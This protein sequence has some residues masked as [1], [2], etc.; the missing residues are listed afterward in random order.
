[1]KRK[2]FEFIRRILFLAFIQ[3]AVSISGQ[4][5]YYVSN[6]GN[7][8]ANGT[9]LGTAWATISKV[10]SATIVPGD[11]VLFQAG[12]VWREE[13]QLTQGASGAGNRVYYGRYGIGNNPKIIGSNKAI[14]WTN[15]A[16]TNVWQSAT[17]VSNP[18][19]GGWGYPGNV[20]FVT[21]DSTSWGVFQD[22][23]ANFSNLS[24][25]LDWTW[26]SNT[27]YVYSPTDP[28]TR[29]DDVE[30]AERDLC[31]GFQNEQ[32]SYIEFNGID[33][34]YSKRA[35]YG[36]MSYPQADNQTDVTIR[37]CNI[38]YIGI[39][40]GAC[41]YGIEAFHSNF[42]VENCTITDC[43][44]RG[45]SFN[46]YEATVDPPLTL[47][48][49]IIRNNVFKRGYHTTSLDIATD[50][51]EPGHSMENIY[52]YNNLVDDHEIQMTGD[53]AGSNQ[54]YFQPY[55]SYFNNI[56]VVNN[57]FI[58]A[59]TRNILVTGGDN[60]YIY[61]NTVFSHN[62][63]ITAPPYSNIN[64][65]RDATANVSNNIIYD[66]LSANT[67]IDNWCIMSDTPDGN[68]VTFQNLDYNLYYHLVQNDVDRGIFGGRDWGYYQMSQWSNF[69]A[70]YPAF[71]VHSPAPAE[72][73]F[74]NKNNFDLTLT[75]NSPA[76]HAGKVLPY[77]LVTD[78]HGR[79]DTIN[80]YDF[81]GNYRSITSP[82]IGAYEYPVTDKSSSHIVFFSI[83]NQES[84][85]VD[86]INHTV[87]V[88][89]PYGTNVTSL[90][91]N[92]IV[93]DFATISP[94]S[95]VARNFTSPV[96]YT[97]TSG[98]GSS[99]H[100]YTVSVVLGNYCN[101]VHIVLN[102]TITPDI[103]DLGNG[104][105][106]LEPT[107]G[108]APYSYSWNNSATSST[109]TDLA[110]GTYSVLVTDNNSC[111]Q[112]GVFIVTQFDNR[113]VDSILISPTYDWLNC[114]SPWIE[115][116][117][118]GTTYYSDTIAISGIF[119]NFNN[120][121]AYPIPKYPDAVCQGN[122]YAENGSVYIYIANISSDYNYDI[123]VMSNRNTAEV[124]TQ[125]TIVNGDSV[126]IDAGDAE[127]CIAYFEDVNP[128][129]DSIIIRATNISTIYS[130][131]NAVKIYVKTKTTEPNTA[132]NIVSFNIPGQVGNSNINATNHTVTV[133]MPNGTNLNSLTPT[134]TISNGATIN[135]TSGIATDFTSAVN[136]TVTAQDET[137]QKVWTVTITIADPDEILEKNKSNT[138][139]VYPVPMGDVLT[140]KFANN[141]FQK[142]SVY[143]MNGKL[144]I[145][146]NIFISDRELQL[147]VSELAKGVYYVTL[148]G[149]GNSLSKLV[150]K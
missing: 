5:T 58:A 11:S 140:L 101:I 131:I 29:Y 9:T 148:F 129:N 32:S 88:T 45:I 68:P 115:M 46:L 74:T 48:N 30:A 99:E 95:G 138:V 64:I 125:Y 124:R 123:E 27:L 34:H 85:V 10:N 136:Y 118:S 96:I 80:K 50:A 51:Q 36:I 20:F 84:S 109:I 119:P 13:L 108:T 33:L 21:D 112:T 111:T 114:P 127:N 41:A 37:N 4:T 61:N 18:R 25:E 91:P 105:I 44:R 6:T 113:I 122:V 92:I 16:Y 77:I 75:E 73:Q 76:T 71:E 87:V 141:K 22:Y 120:T 103:N 89:M 117:A 15:T 69:R 128:I 82:S 130:Y 139:E 59:T 43:G 65:V 55:D 14:T 52:F 72:P 28:D 135:P 38:G 83:P 17:A 94:Q 66:D 132:A 39:K 67:A 8:S 49:I 104:T 57:V 63:N 12:G 107:G 93:S 79:T 56:Y 60:L 86:T 146:K 31:A 35:G 144:L 100:D 149:N 3:C 145:T 116:L 2:T 40:G 134:I 47:S 53:D 150:V 62:H 133:T 90:I 7:N 143:D 106:T 54:V 98:D 19:A 126:L 137:T 147:N 142:A 121:G 110:A 23:T 26:N 42:L 97:V 1:M 102:E 24:A 70:D 81:A 78:A